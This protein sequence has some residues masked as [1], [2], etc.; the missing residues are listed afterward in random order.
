M[1]NEIENCVKSFSVCQ[2]LR[3]SP[4]SVPLHLWQWPSE[5][6]SRLHLDLAGPYMGTHMFFVI[7]D[8]H[9][10][11]L[12]A[13]AMSSIT[14]SKTIEVL[15][16]VF[17]THG[18]SCK[19]VTDNGPSFISQEF[20]SFMRGNGIHHITSFLY[21]LSTNSLVERGVETLKHG[22]K[23]TAGSSVQE[24]LSKF[25]FDYQITPHSTTGVT[26]SELL[27]KR[28]LKS[29]LDFNSSGDIGES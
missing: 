18:L 5:P 21:H 16:T 13:H 24:R 17:A 8:M 29:R 4:C 22:L 27:T 28:Q 11:W 1:T 15:R 12:N 2:E 26:S 6:W 14:S 19:V 7:Q 9:S 23:L 25:L 3:A 20:K 10:K